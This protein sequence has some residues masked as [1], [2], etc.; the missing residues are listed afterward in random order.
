MPQYIVGVKGFVAINCAFAIHLQTT[1]VFGDDERM[2]RKL[3]VAGLLLT[4]GF[5]T[6][7]G[8][9]TFGPDGSRHQTQTGVSET[10]YPGG[11]P[12]DAESPALST[13]TEQKYAREESSS[14]EPVGEIT[15]PPAK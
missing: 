5:L 3:L 12:V 1:T 2:V 13:S 4:A 9:S 14:S 15:K 11:Q 7:C 8:M 6:S 10:G